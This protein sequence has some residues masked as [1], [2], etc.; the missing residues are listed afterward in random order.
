MKVD[1]KNVVQGDARLKLAYQKVRGEVA[2]GDTG[3][4][5]VDSSDKV[6]ISAG[7]W[8]SSAESEMAASRRAKLADIKK[9]VDSGKYF[10]SVPDWK[11][12]APRG[13]SEEVA[14]LQD[15]SK[16]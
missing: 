3:P 2:T 10:E 6:T 5:S 14:L 8:V 13:I 16:R 9:R 15:I 7:S 12:G 1:E 11:L 4:R